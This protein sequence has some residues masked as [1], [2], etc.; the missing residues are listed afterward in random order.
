MLLM[1]V[2]TYALIIIEHV[3]SVLINVL[4][5]QCFNILI[6]IL[7]NISSKSHADKILYATIISPPVR[8]NIV[9]SFKLYLLLDV[10]IQALFNV[11]YFCHMYRK[12]I[13]VLPNGV[14]IIAYEYNHCIKYAMIN[15][16]TQYAIDLTGREYKTRHN[17]YM[18]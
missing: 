12:L 13:S 16:K 3:F 2:C 15:I 11:T 10:Q 1:Y 5:D 18:L 7:S 17:V 9:N 6:Q 8:V 14:L 4:P